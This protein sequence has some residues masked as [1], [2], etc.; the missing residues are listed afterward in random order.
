MK[1]LLLA[2]SVSVMAA[3]AANAAEWGYEGD[4]GP[5]HWGKVAK[6]CE[7][8][9]NQSPIDINNIVEADLKDIKPNYQGNVVSLANNG[10]TLQAA[11]DGENT[12]MI[13]GVEF[14]LKQFHFHTP[15]ENLIRGKQYPLEA[16]FV[17]ADENG[18]LAVIAVMFKPGSENQALKKLS[19]SLPSSGNSVDLSQSFKV[20]DLLP[21]EG[22]YYRFNGSLTTP[23]CSEGVRWYV[24]KDP[25]EMSQAQ[26]ELLKENMGENNRPIQAHNARVILEN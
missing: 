15:S 18:N 10:H 21:K 17:H 6:E 2:L 23:P 7:T 12:L 4:H 11:L 24:M 16:H 25:V 19:Q 9:K 3:G 8:G 26:G 5:E 1:K 20:A 14:E 22:D 13:S